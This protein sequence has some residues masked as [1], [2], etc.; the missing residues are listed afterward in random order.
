MIGA[1]ALVPHV[2]PWGKPWELETRM[3][4]LVAAAALIGGLALMVGQASAQTYQQCQAQAKAYADANVNAGQSAVETGIGGAI[5][6]GI[7]GSFS[8][9]AGKGALTGLGVGAAA[10]L[11]GSEVKWQRLYDAAFQQC[12]NQASYQGQPAYQ[13]PAPA[14]PTCEPLV[15]PQ[16]YMAGHQVGSQSWLYACDAKYNS[17]NPQTWL[18]LGFDGCHHYCRLP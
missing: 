1:T 17:F 18:F 11:V 4:T 7:I 15:P 5:L 14:A 3:K 13:A 6:G 16:G 10:G 9:D 2:G 12:V 8:A